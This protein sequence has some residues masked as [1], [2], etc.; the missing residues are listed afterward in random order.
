MIL[1]PR[2]EDV[3]TTTMRVILAFNLVLMCS[4]FFFE[5]RVVYGGE[6]TLG[7]YPHSVTYA[8]V[9]SLVALKLDDTVTLEQATCIFNSIS[10]LDTSF[11]PKPYGDGF[12]LA[13]I[14]NAH[15]YEDAYDSCSSNSS[16][17]FINPVLRWADDRFM[18]L[19]GRFTALLYD[20]LSNQL[21]SLFVTLELTILDV[22]SISGRLLTLGVVGR[23]IGDAVLIADTLMKT[24]GFQF[25]T[26]ASVASGCL[27]LIPN[28]SLFYKQWGLRDTIGDH[29]VDAD[30]AWSITRG[31]PGVVIGFIDSGIEFD[32]PDLSGLQR[33]QE[34]DIGG[35]YRDSTGDHD[36]IAE[37]I[38]GDSRPACVHGTHTIGVISARTDNSIGIAG[39]APE[40]KVMPVKLYA[41]D[42]FE[43]E[44]NSDDWPAAVKAIL[45]AVRANKSGDTA[46]PL[47]ISIVS[48]QSG[49]PSPLGLASAYIDSLWQEGVLWINSAGNDGAVLWPGYPDPNDHVQAVTAVQ[50]P[51]DIA[52]L[53]A[54]PNVDY[55]A[56]GVGI[57]TLDLPGTA[58]S[59]ATSYTDLPYGTSMAAPVVAGIAAMVYSRRPDLIPAS[60]PPTMLLQILDSSFED[61]VGPAEFDSVGRDWFYG[62]GRANAFR[63][64]IAVTRGDVN[65]DGVYNGVDI[66]RLVNEVLRGGDA[67]TVLHPGLYD[68]NCD[69]TLDLV[70]LV[71]L[72]ELAFRGGANPPPCYIFEY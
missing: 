27:M 3:T 56:P 39:L 54:G 42:D 7:E 70:D 18:Y 46:F 65:S 43:A 62:K 1:D 29:D 34:T 49:Y 50:Y 57:F 69:G 15:S 60:G 21:D 2:H 72:V 31:S 10:I 25:V 66:V 59:E 37:N 40:C 63:P 30:E 28:D 19:K 51:D 45:E 20:S 58:G 38:C 64:L 61:M 22:D 26:P 5:L 24:G 35:A 67:M 23:S 36:K 13:A 6:R 9:D 47:P 71:A 32:H 55:S 33:Y 48:C 14:T 16:V 68:L 53:T 11:T 4:P 41:D 8:I 17:Q 52:Y 44:I 12:W